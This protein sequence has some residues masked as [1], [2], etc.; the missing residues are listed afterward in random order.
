MATDLFATIITDLTAPLDAWLR[1]QGAEPEGALTPPTREGAGDLALAC[2]R[3]ART[4]RKA[5]QLIAAELAKVVAAHPLVARAEA[6]AGFLNV[7][8]AWPAVAARTLDWAETDEGAL[9][10]SLALAGRTIAVEFSSPNT[11][12]PQH[13]GHCRNNILGATVARLLSAVGAKVLRMNLIN[14]RGIH[15]CKSMVAYKLYGDGATP[16]EVGKKGDHLVGDYYVE[17]EKHFAAEY[18]EW[19]ATAAAPLEKDAYFNSKHSALGTAAREMLRAWEAGETE[20]HALWRQMNG[21]CESGFADTYKR[22]GVAFD[23]IYRES[24]TWLL[25]KDLVADGHRRGIFHEA[26]NGALVFDLAR[27]GLEGEKAVL[28]AD[29]TSVY[30]TQDLG[31]AVSRYDEYLFDE[32]IYVVGN[33]QDRHFQVLFGMLAEL[34]PELSGRLHHLSYGMVELPHG[35]MKS[36]EGTV[37][38][39]DDLMD[40][41][42][43][44]AAEAGR[45]RWPELDEGELRQRAEAIAL[46]G[47][48][49]FLLKYAPATS[50]VFDAERSIAFEGETGAYC[51]YA[52]AR[53]TSILRK[54]DDAD[55]GV[56][57]D[58]SAL[59]MPQAHGVLKA[60]L[61]LPGEVLTAARDHKPSL[62]TK[63]TFELA[64]TFAA[65]Y[66]H[67]DCRVIGAPPSE[68][69]A[70]AR[71]VRAARHM[72][73]GALAL[74][75]ITALEEM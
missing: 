61:A 4:L 64:R 14:D 52:Y 41:L 9:G 51:Q 43:A 70:R 57:A 45:A 49:F 3:H 54:L 23:R 42:H 47:L 59:D 37:V 8:L 6:V 35:K 44:M 48:K 15:I 39:A 72:L 31:T 28:R 46:G 69:A 71:L 75:G 63:A 27:I 2:H 13:L 62:L 38:D 16:E 29:G 21:W 18:A 34:R 50:F 40:D 22:M 58:L 5:P 32:M 26:A 36:R 53:A 19:S 56:E 1:A 11:N 68:M 24:E 65:F 7:H 74:L 17:F 25:G 12:K 33:E 20:V 67:P 60:M 66:N 55:A 73:G 30:V 10:H